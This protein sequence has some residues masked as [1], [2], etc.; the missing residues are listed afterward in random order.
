VTE[1]A[2]HRA[3]Q[4]VIGPGEV[5]NFPHHAAGVR[6]VGSQAE[7]KNRDHPDAAV[8]LLAERQGLAGERATEPFLPNW[9]DRRVQ[10]ACRGLAGHFLRGLA[11]QRHG[12][13]IDLLEHTLFVHDPLASRGLIE[14]DLGWRTVVFGHRKLLHST[15][16]RTGRHLSR[17]AH[18]ART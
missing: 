3:A 7:R 6:C 9:K 4:L 8:P 12:V 18:S 13:A 15:T 11:E 2:R 10:Y 14:K 17:I 1:R 5:G 16:G